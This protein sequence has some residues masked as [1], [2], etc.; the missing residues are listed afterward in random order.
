[1]SLVSKKYSS[2]GFLVALLF[3]F[4]IAD[5]NFDNLAISENGKA[6]LLI[7]AGTI[8]IIALFFL[9]N[10]AKKVE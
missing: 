10:R 7:G 9:S 2:L 3:A 1:M 4:G 5:L 8:A 6:Y